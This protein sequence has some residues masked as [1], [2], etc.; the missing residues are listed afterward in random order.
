[1]GKQCVRCINL[2][3]VS[4]DNS[5]TYGVIIKGCKYHPETTEILVCIINQPV[6]RTEFGADGT[7]VSVTV[8]ADKSIE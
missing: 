4:H 5:L 3:N 2:E 1:M 6:K 7:T 8:T